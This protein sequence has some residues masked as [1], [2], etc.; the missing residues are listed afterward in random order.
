MALASPI[1][2]KFAFTPFRQ[3][4]SKEKKVFANGVLSDAEDATLANDNSDVGVGKETALAK[5]DHLL[6]KRVKVS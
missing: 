6:G 4:P 3:L 2:K 5:D 1:W